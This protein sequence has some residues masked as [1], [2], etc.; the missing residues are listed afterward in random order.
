VLAYFGLPSKFQSAN[1]REFLLA[2]LHC[3]NISICFSSEVFFKTKNKLNK[4]IN[5]NDFKAILIE[6]QLK[7]FIFVSNLKDYKDDPKNS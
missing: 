5:L 1:R 7:I 2:I 6:I 3:S 4:K